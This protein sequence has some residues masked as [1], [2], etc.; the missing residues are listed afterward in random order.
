MP[1][2]RIIT[3]IASVLVLLDMLW[4]VIRGVK[5]GFINKENLTKEFVL[6]AVGI[7]ILA[8]AIIAISWF[9]EF[10]RLGDLIFCGCGILAVEFEN[11]QMLGL[12]SDE[13]DTDYNSK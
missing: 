13:D 6:K 3:L 10:G 11:R 1:Q 12:I 5:N 8:A 7:Y 9:R 2:N 4:F